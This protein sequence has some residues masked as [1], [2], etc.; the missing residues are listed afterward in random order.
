VYQLQ[1]IL[2]C[3]FLKFPKNLQKEIGKSP[4][5]STVLHKY[6]PHIQM[7]LESRKGACHGFVIRWETLIQKNSSTCVP[8]EKNSGR[9]R[10]VVKVIEEKGQMMGKVWVVLGDG[11][12]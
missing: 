6:L 12:G 9:M 4:P 5:T 11:L 2:G 7:C 10:D 8:G 1:R 3:L